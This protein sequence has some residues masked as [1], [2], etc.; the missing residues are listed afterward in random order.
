MK[1]SLVFLCILLSLPSFA[2]T[3][4][5]EKSQKR[6]STELNI[7]YVKDAEQKLYSFDEQALFNHLK[8]NNGGDLTLDIDGKS[9][10]LKFEPVDILHEDFMIYSNGQRNSGTQVSEQILTYK[11]FSESDPGKESRFTITPNSIY[12]KI[13]AKN[14]VISLLSRKNLKTQRKEVCRLVIFVKR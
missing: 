4:S 2:Q 12:G 6:S 8:D 13:N 14:D 3:F 1:N 7:N 10:A 9:H 5:F 11:V